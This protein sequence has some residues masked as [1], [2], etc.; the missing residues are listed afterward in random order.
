MEMAET[1]SC[2]RQPQ[3][4]STT[5]PLSRQTC[6]VAKRS[7]GP[8]TWPLYQLSSTASTAARAAATVGARSRRRGSRQATSAP[9]QATTSVR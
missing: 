2:A 3:G 6:A 7:T 9:R 1:K 4:S 8:S 5:R